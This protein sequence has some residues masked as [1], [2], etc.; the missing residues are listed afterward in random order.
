MKFFY[1]ILA[2][3][4]FAST[5]YAQFNEATQCP[6]GASPRSDVFGCFRFENL[7]NCTTG[8]EDLCWQDNTGLT[9]FFTN[10]SS[11]SKVQTDEVIVGS[12]A[13]QQGSRWGGTSGGTEDYTFPSV[14]QEIKIRYYFKFANNYVVYSDNVGPHGLTLRA[15]GTCG[16]RYGLEHIS[17]GLDSYSFSDNG[18]GCSYTQADSFLNDTVTGPLAHGQWYL[19][20]LEAKMDTFCT[21]VTAE[22]GCNGVL[23]I[24]IDGVTTYTRSDVNWG[25]VDGLAQGDANPGFWQYEFADFYKHDGSPQWE[26]PV[27]FD[28]FVFSNDADLAIGESTTL[29]AKGTGSTFQYWM[30]PGGADTVVIDGGDF[31]GG[32]SEVGDYFC[33]VQSDCSCFDGLPFGT[34]AWFYYWLTSTSSIMYPSIADFKANTSFSTLSL[35]ENEWFPG[36]TSLNCSGGAGGQTGNESD[37]SMQITLQGSLGENETFFIMNRPA[38]EFVG[39]NSNNARVNDWFVNAAIYP[40][41]TNDYSD[42]LCLGGLAERHDATGPVGGAV[43]RNWVC[44][45]ID[46][47]GDGNPAN[48]TWTLHQKVWSGAS[49][50]TNAVQVDTGKTVDY[51][52]WSTFEVGVNAAGTTAT[53]FIRGVQYGG[54]IVLDQPMDD[55]QSPGGYLE[56]GMMGVRDYE[57]T[58]DFVINYDFP[59]IGNVSK[60]SP[61]LGWDPGFAPTVGINTA[62]L[63]NNPDLVQEVDT[64][65]PNN[66]DGTGVACSGTIG[67][68]G[69]FNTLDSVDGQNLDLPT[70]NQNVVVNVR[71]STPDTA[72]VTFDGWITTG[73]TVTLNFESDYWLSSALTG[74]QSLLIADDNFTFNN[75]QCELTSSSNTGAA[76]VRFGDGNNVVFNNPKFRNSGDCSTD[77][78][79]CTAV[80]FSASS[81]TEK[82]V[83]NPEITGLWNAGVRFLDKG[84][85]SGDWGIMQPTIYGVDDVG[86]Y[87]DDGDAGCTG[88]IVIKNALIQGG[89]EVD[90]YSV[91][92]GNCNVV[93]DSIMTSD[94]TSP[95][96]ALRNKTVT[97]TSIPGLDFRI[98][99]TDTSGALTSG[100]DLSSDIFFPVTL[101]RLGTTRTVPYTIGAYETE[102]TAPSDW[103]G[104]FKRNLCF[105]CRRSR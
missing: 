39:E 104:W 67:G 24:K 46:D 49:L 105:W 13:F 86:I 70:L 27:Y 62:S 95:Q 58:T 42:D 35:D 37:G 44:V 28:E 78:L 22:D 100:V 16:K 54:T 60:E 81:T 12:G 90:D 102:A 69:A 55:A 87:I 73:Y 15:N 23:T 11:N 5:S 64:D 6:G 38:P 41:S 82:W 75:L 96:V 47:K 31:T 10:S 61:N 83:I 2:L 26:P 9:P 30:S 53:F 98:V 14:V 34:K 1:Q 40:R 88:N 33:Y 17:Y 57:G 94:A 18:G 89:T 76:C 80:D 7:A 21:D 50:S 74:G 19:F 79:A 51:D 32:G 4:I 101:D 20:E 3:L 36:G 92:S 48:D 103:P 25:R 71:G 84:A 97:F 77:N 56:Y 52:E 68:P 63:F 99:G 29:P 45:S 66:G 72:S 59:R 85:G 65:C 8:Q 43:A 93:T 91:V